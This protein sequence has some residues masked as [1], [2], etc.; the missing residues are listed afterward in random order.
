MDYDPF[1]IPRI[2][3]A[4]LGRAV[5]CKVS[6]TELKRRSPNR[7]GHATGT[8]VAEGLMKIVYGY[9]QT[10]PDLRRKLVA[11]R[12]QLERGTHCLGGRNAPALY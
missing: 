1:R 4:H 11:P 9:R 8:K 10:Q 7:S 5:A 2:A 12:P 3:L 6:A